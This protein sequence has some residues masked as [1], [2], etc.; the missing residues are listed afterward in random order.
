MKQKQKKNI[1]TEGQKNEN[2]SIMLGFGRAQAKR[3]YFI[4]MIF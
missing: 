4:N 2:G 3:H 1:V